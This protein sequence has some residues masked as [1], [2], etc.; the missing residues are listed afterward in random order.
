VPVKRSPGRR[1]RLNRIQFTMR[2]YGPLNEAVIAAGRKEGRSDRN[3]FLNVLI[4]DGLLARRHK[5]PEVLVE[6]DPA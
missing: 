4:R 2:I 6:L 5:A 1:R 3:E